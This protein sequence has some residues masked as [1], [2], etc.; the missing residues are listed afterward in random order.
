MELAKG[1]YVNGRGIICRADALGREVPA[2]VRLTCPH[3]GHVQDRR[4]ARRSG[5]V[6]NKCQQDMD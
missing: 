3:C 4:Y 1:Q 6:C 5:N 2:V